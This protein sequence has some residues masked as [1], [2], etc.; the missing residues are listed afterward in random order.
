M[1]RPA[2]YRKQICLRG[3]DTFICGR[4]KSG[5]CRDCKREDQ[6]KNNDKNRGTGKYRGSD[7]RNKYGITLEDYNRIFNEQNGKC[8]ICLL[9][10]SKM[11]RRLCVDHDHKRNKVRGLLC[12]NCNTGIGRFWENIDLFNKAIA[13]IRLH[14]KENL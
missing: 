9:P 13:Y 4:N 14:S 3:H 2:G 7:L 12:Y 10:Q 11:K 5:G 8:A 1:S 6:K